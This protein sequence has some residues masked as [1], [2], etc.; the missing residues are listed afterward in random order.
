MGGN[1]TFQWR[2][3]FYLCSTFCSMM[4]IIKGGSGAVTVIKIPFAYLSFV[5]QR[6]RAGGNKEPLLPLL[7]G[8][9]VVILHKKPKNG[10]RICTF[11]VPGG[12]AGITSRTFAPTWSDH[13]QQRLCLSG[14]NLK[15]GEQDF[16]RPEQVDFSSCETGIVSFEAG[17]WSLLTSQISGWPWP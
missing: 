1:H 17:Q 12:G 6:R 16:P 13:D 3:A 11:T 4:M 15:P 8:N 2:S 5:C 7:E 9:Q 10:S 14:D